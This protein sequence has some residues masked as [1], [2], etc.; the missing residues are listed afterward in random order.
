MTPNKGQK[1]LILSHDWNELRVTFDWKPW[2][3]PHD[4]SVT[5]PLRTISRIPDIGRV[6]TSQWN[7]YMA[8]FDRSFSSCHD[9]IRYVITISSFLEA[10][11]TS[12]SK[13]TVNLIGRAEWYWESSPDSSTQFDHNFWQKR[14]GSSLDNFIYVYYKYTFFCRI[15]SKIYLTRTF[16][17]NYEFH[18][19]R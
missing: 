12:Y 9:F 5:S 6:Y 19:E 16:Y 14:P 15:V 17:L 10:I 4:K 13:S 11:F 1:S 8:L 3:Y 2:T 18:C 7:C